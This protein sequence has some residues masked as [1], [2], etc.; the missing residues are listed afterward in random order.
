MLCTE[1]CVEHRSWVCIEIQPR[2]FNCVCPS[3]VST[4]SVCVQSLLLL[5]TNDRSNTKKGASRYK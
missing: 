3:C 4:V 5:I 2:F 1:T